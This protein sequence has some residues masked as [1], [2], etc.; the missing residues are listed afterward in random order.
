MRPSPAQAPS[1]CR[2]YSVIAPVSN[3]SQTDLAAFP[4]LKC[5]EKNIRGAMPTPTALE[6]GQQCAGRG[7]KC[8][9]QVL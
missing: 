9:R 6:W 4:A 8:K 1:F 7:N 3:R 5:I 2:L